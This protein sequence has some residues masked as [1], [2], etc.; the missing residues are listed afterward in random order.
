MDYQSRGSKSAEPAQR[1]G[2]LIRTVC[3][4]CKS[5]SKKKALA[6]DFPE[7][8]EEIPEECVGST[9]RLCCAHCGVTYH[10]VLEH[11]QVV[12]NPGQ[13]WISVQVRL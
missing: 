1:C 2:H 11:L 9:L 5:N 10:N 7:E 13:G 6:R 4:G 8:L 3:T 12:K